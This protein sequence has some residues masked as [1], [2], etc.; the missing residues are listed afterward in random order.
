MSKA[1]EMADKN[2][3]WSF[4]VSAAQ[5][6]E[7]GSHQV[8]ETTPGQRELIAVAAGLR[9]VSEAKASFALAHSPG[10]Q[11]HVTGRVQA[12]VEQ[13]C[14]VTLDPVESDVDEAVDIMF[15][16]PSQIP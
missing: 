14:V 11:V 1:G 15:A 7:G 3:P 10:G 13:T 8:L 5:L 4:P 12:R 16:P 9:G 6:P 2:I